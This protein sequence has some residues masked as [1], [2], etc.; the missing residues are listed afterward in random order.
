MVSSAAAGLLLL[1]LLHRQWKKLCCLLLWPTSWLQQLSPINCFLWQRSALRLSIF[2]NT[3]C[4]FGNN[5]RKKNVSFQ[6]SNL[7]PSSFPSP[8]FSFIGRYKTTLLIIDYLLPTTAQSKKHKQSKP[9]AIRQVLPSV[10]SC[11]C[12]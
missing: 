7:T 11:Y 12:C 1:L 6:I 4:G 9:Q 8:L 3:S 5:R 2:V 10:V